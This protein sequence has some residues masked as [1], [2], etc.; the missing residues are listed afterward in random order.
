MCDKI[1]K[2][3]KMDVLRVVVCL[4]SMYAPRG[5]HSF[6]VSPCMLSKYVRIRLHSKQFTGGINVGLVVG[7]I[8]G[9]VLFTVLVVLAAIGVVIFVRRKKDTNDRKQM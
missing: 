1:H 4:H 2:S 9:V 8:M 6:M 3:A 5:K 7:V